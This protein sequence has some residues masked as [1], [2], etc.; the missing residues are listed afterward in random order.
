M[1]LRFANLE[2]QD[3]YTKGSVQTIHVKRVDPDPLLPDKSIYRL[4]LKDIMQSLDE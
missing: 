3:W 1:K 4:I 2:K